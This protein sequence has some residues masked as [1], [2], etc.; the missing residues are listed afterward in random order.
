MEAS[1]PHNLHDTLKEFKLAS[2]KTGK[3]YSLHDVDL[4]A[5]FD[6]AGGRVL[7]KPDP[8]PAIEAA[9]NTATARQFLAFSQAPYWRVTPVEEP[10]RGSK[11]EIMDLRFG[12]PGEPRF[13]ATIMTGE[14]G[15]VLR[16]DF[17]FRTPSGR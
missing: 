14:D 6:P 17:S 16:E 7:Y 9:R 15:R 8:Q 4:R 2:G 5:Q 13:V 3:F 10:W 1:M 12:S 11:V